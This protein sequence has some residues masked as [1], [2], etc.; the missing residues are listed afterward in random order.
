MAY[1]LCYFD[2]VK[3]DVK[4]AKIWYKKQ[5]A[6]LEK[7]FAASIKITLSRIKENP[8]MYAVQYNNIRI[9]RPKI[10]PYNI[11]FYVDNMNVN[12]I[13]IA[14]IHNKRDRS[15]VFKRL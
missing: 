15:V 5:R 13:I 12:V 14:I 9:A 11:Y 4:E 10:F 3:F 1:R 7:R 6:G 8:F 2:E